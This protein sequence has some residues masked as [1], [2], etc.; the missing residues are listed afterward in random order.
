MTAPEQLALPNIPPPPFTPR[1]PGIHT[2]DHTALEMFLA[3]EF[4]GVERFR[5]TTDSTRLPAVV[6]RLKKLGWPISV[7]TVPEPSRRR[8]DRHVGVWHLPRQYRAL[9]QELSK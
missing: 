8:R 1:W 3:G 6:D 5:Q 9:A 7:D 4:V 2:I